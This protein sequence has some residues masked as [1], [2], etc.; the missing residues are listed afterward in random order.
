VSY[1]V[2]LTDG[3][4]TVDM[5]R[6]GSGPLRGIHCYDWS[7]LTGAPPKRGRNRRIPGA[8]GTK[9]RPR[10]A[11]ELRA[12]LH[13]RVIGDDHDDCLE[14]LD[15]L[16]DLIDQDDPLTVTVHRGSLPNLTGELQVE[17]PDRPTIR[18]PVA[19]LVIEVTVA[20]GRLEAA[21]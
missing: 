4:S 2:V 15:T 19:T 17:D 16:Y 14:Y 13:V 8:R 5:R 1:G 18:G 6:N 20:D 12:L 7:D 3:T 21:S 11:G 10:N 9:V